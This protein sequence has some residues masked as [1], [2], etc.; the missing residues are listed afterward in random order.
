MPARRS[1]ARDA[2]AELAQRE[3]LG[4][5]VV[6]AEL[7][8]EDLVDLLGLGG[9]HDD[10]D[11]VAGADPPADLQPVHPG[12][13]HVEHDEVEV[14]LVEAR[15]RLTAVGG[16]RHLVAVLAQREAQQRLDRLLVVGQQDSGC[17]FGHRVRAHCRRMLDPRLYR[18]AF[19]PV[20]LALL[21]AAFSLQERPRPIGTTQAPGGLRRDPGRSDARRPRPALPGPPP[22]RRGRRRGWR[23]R[24]RARLRADR[25]RHRARSTT[26]RAR[27]STASATSSTSS[28]RGRARPGPP[29]VVVAHRDAA[30]PGV[31]R[32]SCRRP[33]RCWSSRASRPTAGCAGPSPSSR[34]AGGSGG[35]AGA[36]E[37]ARRIAER[38]RRRGARPR[39]R[40]GARTPRGRSSCRS[41]TAAGQAPMQLQR[42]VQARGARGGRHRR[43]RAAR[44]RRSGCGWPCR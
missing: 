17:A 14:A 20:L 31:A 21:V 33:P 25:A 41:P 28:P 35:F 7:E 43:R 13:H 5:V 9:E 42:T 24:S 16:G 27:R 34:P 22:G 4:D 2:A 26:S 10:R 38:P 8:A 44:A 29:I 39:R 11:G 12:H 19:V 6:G 36:R 3:R 32:P 30:E 23:A 18:V 37:E 40:G 15:Q 1:A